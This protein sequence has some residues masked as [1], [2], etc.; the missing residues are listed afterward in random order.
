MEGFDRIVA[1]VLSTAV[2]ATAAAAEEPIREFKR[3]QDFCALR[4]TY[5]DLSS[6]LDRARAIVA[7]ANA[8]T[9]DYTL[10][11]LTISAGA[12]EV[13]FKEDFSRAALAHAPA[14]ATSLTYSYYRPSAPIS[15]IT[16]RLG[17]HSREL[18]VSG[19][20][21]EQ[22][23][24]L[25]LLV[26]SDLDKL[27]CSMGGTG[28]RALGGVL[29][30]VAAMGIGLL[31]AA[32]IVKK[33]IGNI[34]VLGTVIVINVSLWTLPW[35]EWFPGTAI[36]AGSQSF[37]DRHAPLIGFGGLV[38]GVASLFLAAIPLL[39]RIRWRTADQRNEPE[40]DEPAA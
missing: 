28:M 30:L 22:V 38:V 6:L 1:T 12:D 20:S 23:E 16:L 21:R 40:N 39:G 13:T 7:D 27:G 10:E 29:L 15:D 4:M 36:T 33:A 25:V 32:G 37:I 31:P 19:S 35:Q 8:G 26:S 17:D 3:S 2:L 9:D 34:L 24:S 5:A 11:R 18:E 14:L